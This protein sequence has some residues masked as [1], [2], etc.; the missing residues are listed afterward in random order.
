MQCLTNFPSILVF[1]IKLLALA[2]TDEKK[3]IG[4]GYFSELPGI[5]EANNGKKR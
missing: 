2:E 1:G 3:K 4:G 5:L